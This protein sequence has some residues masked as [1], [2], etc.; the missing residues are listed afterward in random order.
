MPKIP[1][2]K[3][4][5]KV[6]KEENKEDEQFIV[7]N[8]VNPAVQ[9]ISGY[10]RCLKE[11]TT[12]RFVVNNFPQYKWKINELIVM[13]IENYKPDLRVELD[14]R[15]IIVEVDE[16][17]HKY[18]GAL[19]ET[20]RILKICNEVYSKDVLFIR[21]NPD[22]YMHE[23]KYISGCWEYDE[24][25]KPVI[26]NQIEWD[27]RLKMLK[28]TIEE[29]I[30]C[31]TQ[32][33]IDLIYLFYS[34]I[35][36]NIL[37]AI[38]KDIK[39]NNLIYELKHDSQN[40]NDKLKIMFS[41]KT[42]LYK[43]L[44]NNDPSLLKIG[45]YVAYIIV[46]EVLFKQGGKITRMRQ[47]GKYYIIEYTSRNKLYTFRSNDVIIYYR[48]KSSAEIR[49]ENR[50]LWKE[51]QKKKCDMT[52]AKEIISLCGKIRKNIKF[53]SED[54]YLNSPE[55]KIDE[56][57]TE[58]AMKYYGIKD[59]ESVQDI[60]IYVDCFKRRLFPVP[61]WCF[62]EMCILKRYHGK[63][64]YEEII[65]ESREDFEKIYGTKII[66]ENICHKIKFFRD[67]GFDF[68]NCFPSYKYN[69][70]NI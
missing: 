41:D 31:K 5:L 16:N 70:M 3:K 42:R 17:Q 8:F 32:E 19:A 68:K 40:E 33:K 27:Y 54:E 61:I 26:K 14:D 10:I 62:V 48:E 29:C 39:C 6:E 35:N 56:R 25:K 22:E 18:Y 64:N 49:I 2:V 59:E 24:N 20:N 37:H 7:K 53:E 55:C 46:D 4:I 36:K 23:D 28:A 58:L 1:K 9:R 52:P 12:I 67:A 69:L 43:L 66:Y 50:I 21:F 57:I 34:N 15:I 51:E 11:Y 44:E 47:N 60:K 63:D 13:E 38:D 45:N 30:Q 65:E